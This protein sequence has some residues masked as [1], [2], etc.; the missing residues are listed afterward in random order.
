[1]F[2]QL[3]RFEYNKSTEQIQLHFRAKF[4]MASMKCRSRLL[5]TRKTKLLRFIHAWELGYFCKSRGSVF[6]RQYGFLRLWG[7]NPFRYCFDRCHCGA[8]K[9]RC[10]RAADKTN[11]LHMED[12]REKT[13]S[14]SEVQF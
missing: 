11:F 5:L 3:P 7:H 10:L 9:M 13:D 12:W 8:I 4:V 14:L 6:G 1:M 2:N